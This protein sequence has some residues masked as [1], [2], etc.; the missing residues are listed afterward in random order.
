MTISLSISMILKQIN[1]GIKIV[2]S[3]VQQHLLS[4]NEVNILCTVFNANKL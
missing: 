4:C 1:I 2:I 3:L